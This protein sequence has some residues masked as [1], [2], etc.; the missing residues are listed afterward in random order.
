MGLAGTFHI[1][2]SI[3]SIIDSVVILARIFKTVCSHPTPLCLPVTRLILSGLLTNSCALHGRTMSGTIYH[4]LTVEIDIDNDNIWKFASDS[5]RI[6]TNACRHTLR[7]CYEFEDERMSTLRAHNRSEPS[8]TAGQRGIVDFSTRKSPRHP[9]WPTL[10]VISLVPDGFRA[11]Y[12]VDMENFAAYA[13][14]WISGI[15]PSKAEV[16]K[17]IVKSYSRF[18]AKTI[19]SRSKA[20]IIVIA[21]SSLIQFCESRRAIFRENSIEK[22]GCCYRFYG[23]QHLRSCAYLNCSDIRVH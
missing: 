9:P 14:A 16:V 5:I 6:F 15:I 4:E 22:L 1:S 21:Q 12:Y 20:D 8:P 2:S 7:S 11:F 19:G 13:S 18:I 10:Q 17:S 3:H 23:Q